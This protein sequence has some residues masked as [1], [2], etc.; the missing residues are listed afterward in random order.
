MCVCE[1][2]VEMVKVLWQFIFGEHLN[3]FKSIIVIPWLF[4]H[5]NVKSLIYFE[6]FISDFFN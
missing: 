3:I 4:W 1:V 2:N 6:I 5:F